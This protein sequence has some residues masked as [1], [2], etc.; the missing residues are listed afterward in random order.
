M[1]TLALRGGS[2]R[3]CRRGGKLASAAAKKKPVR[4]L[5]ARDK[6]G[7]FRTHGHN[8]VATARGTSWVTHDRCNGTLTRVFEG[9]VSVRDRTAK[10]TVLVRAGHKYLARR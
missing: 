1:T 3:S 8:S 5:W 2:F 9:A 4:S 7:R 6:N 10:R